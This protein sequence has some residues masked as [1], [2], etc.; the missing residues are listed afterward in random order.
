[1]DAIGRLQI[2]S[3]GVHL[4]LSARDSDQSRQRPHGRGF[5]GAVSTQ[6]RNDLSFWHVERKPLKDKKGTI[7]GHE[8]FHLK[9]LLAQGT[10]CE[11]PGPTRL[12]CRSPPL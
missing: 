3:V 2:D 6:Q 4:Y 1:M 10:L 12:L 9:H 8:F 5:A 7:S 11:R